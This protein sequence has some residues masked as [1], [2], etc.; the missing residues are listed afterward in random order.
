MTNRGVSD[1]PVFAAC[2][3]KGRPRRVAYA[4]R[5][6]VSAER[7]EHR[8]RAGTAGHVAVQVTGFSLRQRPRTVPAMSRL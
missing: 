8:L 7:G 4:P 1:P 5:A 2:P 6:D 3:F